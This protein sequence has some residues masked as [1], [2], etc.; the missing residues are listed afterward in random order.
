MVSTGVLRRY[1]EWRPTPEERAEYGLVKPSETPEPGQ[2]VVKSQRVP[3][4]LDDGRE[5]WAVDV[6]D[7]TESFGEEIAVAVPLVIA[8]F[9]EPDL[10]VDLSVL[11]LSGLRSFGGRGFGRDQVPGYLAGSW[12]VEQVAQWVE[13]VGD[14]AEGV[15]ADES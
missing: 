12:S 7:K 3:V 2:L 14:Y 8:S 6:L 15:L 5:V 4:E 11:Q 1:T 13:P 9:G 10:P